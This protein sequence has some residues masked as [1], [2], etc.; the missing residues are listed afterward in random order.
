V[1]FTPT[2][3]VA[4]KGL[5]T[6]RKSTKRLVA[7]PLLPPVPFVVRLIVTLPMINDAEAFTVNTPAAVL[8]IVYVHVAT[9]PTK[10]TADPHVVLDEEGAGLTDGEMFAVVAGVAPP[11]T[12]VAVIV[13]TC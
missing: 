7:G 13:K 3:L 8:L 9:L 5:A 1:W 6:I 10:G 2:L 11:G 12:C 4:V